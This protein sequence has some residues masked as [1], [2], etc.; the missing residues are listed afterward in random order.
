MANETN[1][2]SAKTDWLVA[3]GESANDEFSSRKKIYKTARE[4]FFKDLINDN[5]GSS[6]Q[7]SYDEFKRSIADNNLDPIKY[8]PKV[9]VSGKTVPTIVQRSGTNKTFAGSLTSLSEPR[10]TNDAKHL[11]NS[12]TFRNIIENI[13]A[14]PTATP[15][16]SGGQKIAT[17]YDSQMQTNSS[18]G[19]LKRRK[20]VKTA[21]LSNLLR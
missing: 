19:S 3:S 4:E 10:Q 21:N 20:E 1:I 2:R 15:H 8:I 16:H 18:Y 12:P 5:S 13:K 7:T 11:G 17:G 9:R 14:V 6:H